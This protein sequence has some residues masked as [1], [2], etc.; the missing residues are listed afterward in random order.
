MPLYRAGSGL[1]VERDAQPAERA[2]VGPRRRH[3]ARPARSGSASRQMITSPARSAPPPARRSVRHAGDDGRS[4]SPIASADLRLVLGADPPRTT[5]RV[6]VAQDRPRAGDRA[7]RRS[8]HGAVE[9]VAREDRLEVLERQ[10]D[11][12]DLDR[13]SDRADARRFRR[14]SCA[15]I[16]GSRPA[17]VPPAERVPPP[18]C[19]P[20]RRGQVPDH[21]PLRSRG[22]P[23]PPAR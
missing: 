19:E 4:M 17:R 23:G 10:V 1:I 14:R 22:A 16:S 6:D 8:S 13:R 11:V 12:D 7:R 2:E 15:A 20:R 18:G 21:R 5:S 3:R 9:D